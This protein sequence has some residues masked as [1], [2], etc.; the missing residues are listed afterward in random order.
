MCCD[1]LDVLIWFRLYKRTKLLDLVKYPP[2]SPYDMLDTLHIM[3]SGI[4]L[5]QGTYHAGYTDGKV[6]A[7]AGDSAFFHACLPGLVNAVLLR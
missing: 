1:F 3:R 6:V 7:V 2:D 4:C 5:A